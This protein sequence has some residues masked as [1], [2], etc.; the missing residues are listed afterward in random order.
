[1]TPSQLIAYL[2]VAIPNNEITLIKGGVGIGKTDC[3]NQATKQVKYDIQVSHSVVDSPTDFKGFGSKSKDGD[4]AVWL[5]YDQLHFAMTAKKPLVWFFDDFGQ[6]PPTVQA[7][8]AQL[9]LGRQINGKRISDKVVFLIATNRKEDK[10]H[11]TGILEMT[12]GRTRIVELILDHNDWLLWGEDEDLGNMPPELL[13]FI[14]WQPDW[15]NKPG[16][17]SLDIVNTHNPRNIARV[18]KAMCLGYPREVE[19]DV[20]AGDAG[21]AFADSF[22]SFLSMLRNRIDPRVVLLDPSKYQDPQGKERPG[23]LYAFSRAIALNAEK[24]LM[25]NVFAISQLIPP[26]FAAMMMATIEKMKPELKETK[27]FTQWAI[28]A[29][30]N[31]I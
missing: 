31:K 5:P 2:K 12:K 22:M 4:Y 13:A 11:V 1:M 8:A 3:V 14:N 7:A 17:P 30:R 18:G 27:G 21:E 15:I 28:A 25:D 26:E 6:A 19:R 10:S 20:Y 16:K 9:F 23:V 24:K 29:A